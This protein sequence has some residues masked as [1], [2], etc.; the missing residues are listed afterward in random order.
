MS[1]RW[2][3]GEELLFRGPLLV[4]ARLCAV[5]HPRYGRTVMLVVAALSTVAFA[6]WHLEFG[7]VNVAAAAAYGTMWAAIALR[8][9]SLWPAIVAHSVFDAWLFL[10]A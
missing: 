10:H 6:F 8:S 1:W 2:G 9:R 7:A 3:S 5:Y 4:A